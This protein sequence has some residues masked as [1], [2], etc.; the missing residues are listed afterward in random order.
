MKDTNAIEK[1]IIDKSKQEI[2]LIVSEFISDVQS[3]LRNKY[4][5]CSFYTVNHPNTNDPRKITVM[6]EHELLKLLCAMLEEGHMKAM[7]NKKSKELLN[8]LELI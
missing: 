1:A 3:K 4:N 5:T 7:V 2:A 8:K 6:G